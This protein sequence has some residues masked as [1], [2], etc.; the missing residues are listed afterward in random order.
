MDPNISIVMSV[1]EESIEQLQRA[2]DSILGQSFK[3]IEFI[4][5]LDNPQ[6]IEAREYIFL[7]QEWDPRIVF[8]ENKK[9]IKLWAS[10]N[11]GISKASW[12]YI[13]RM[14]GDDICASSKLQK[15]YEYLAQNEE[16]DLLFTGWEE[17][18]EV[19]S[20]EIRIPTRDDFRNIEKTFFYKSPILH[21]SMM[22]KK[23]IFAKYKY[24]EID[25]PEDFSL[26]L[27]LIHAG[28]RFD[29]L[30]ES[31]YIFY[32]QHANT[33]KKYE[34]I[35]AFSSNYFG[36]LWKNISKFWRNMYFWWMFL[37]TFIQWILSRNRWIFWIFFEWLQGL[38]KKLFISSAHK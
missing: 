16:I 12:K 10:L 19:W 13:A 28:Y 11:R 34:K 26:F 3:D 22:C 9:N 27:N 38:Y 37:V 2:I 7:R 8:L 36:I 20:K 14:D 18:D 6:N 32:V 35:R 5:I 25:R 4:I 24:P 31:L 1:Y 30:E 33:E 29:I 21:A 17:Q 23:E 15:Q